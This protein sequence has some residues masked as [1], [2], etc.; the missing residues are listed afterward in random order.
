MNP[1][2]R[3]WILLV[4]GGCTLGLGSA[5][6]PTL[7]ESPANPSSAASGSFQAGAAAIEIT[8]ET[9]PRIIA[10]GFLEQQASQV[11]S[12]LFARGIVLSDGATK[13]AIVVVDTCMMTQRLIDEAK[14]LA[15]QQC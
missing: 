13:L 9:F 1:V 2:P 12:P 8:P 5:P 6:S 11:S 15:S 3:I 7:A 14:E 4:F 10:G